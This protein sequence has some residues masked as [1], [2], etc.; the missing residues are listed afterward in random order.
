MPRQLPR[1][2]GSGQITLPN[3]DETYVYRAYCLCGDLL[4][5]G[6]THNLFA[7]LTD[8]ARS[9][10]RWELKAVRIEWDIYRTRLMAERV[11][12]HL[13]RTLDP[14]FNVLGRSREFRRPRWV[15]LPPLQPPPSL[16]D[17]ARDAH[18]LLARGDRA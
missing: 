3:A 18:R 2:T 6:I 4:Y 16:D 11:E 7:R 1:P 9:R 8:H 14:V 10:A 12:S 13:I 15:N 5:V 17:R